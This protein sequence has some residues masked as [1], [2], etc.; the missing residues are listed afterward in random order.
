M[1]RHRLVRYKT[2]HSRTRQNRIK[3]R[4][5]E[6]ETF[7]KTFVSFA[8]G[9]H[10]FDMRLR[11]GILHDT[12]AQERMFAKEAEAA[13]K[14]KKEAETTTV[15]TESQQKVHDAEV[16]EAEHKSAQAQAK[17]KA[18][19]PKIKPLSETRAIDLGANFASESFIFMVAAGLLVFE[20][21]WS[22]R[23]ETQ[24]DEH[25]VERLKA[26]E[27]QTESISYLE[28]EVERLRAEVK[29]RDGLLNTVRTAFGGVAGDKSQ[30]RKPPANA[31]T[32]R[33]KDSEAQTVS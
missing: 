12:A 31:S 2:D 25:V 27:D 5:R 32:K 7:R 30:E 9:L 18:P 15:R 29:A 1:K 24:K 21:W 4:A 13:A 33:M 20:R 11:L 19:T 3:A 14:R 6:H 16:E 8:Q 22:K 26:L 23:K 17:E 10:R 28:A